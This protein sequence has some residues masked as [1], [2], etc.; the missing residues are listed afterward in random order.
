MNAAFHGRRTNALS[1]LIVAACVYQ[2]G[3][4]SCGCLDHHGWYQ[5]WRQ[6]VGE[7]P[8]GHGHTADTSVEASECEAA[9]SL[10]ALY[11]PTGVDRASA[12]V[13][14]YAVADI[15]AAREFLFARLATPTAD[16]GI[17][18]LAPPLRAEFQVYRL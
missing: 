9:P 12:P 6:V 16:K 10:D 8:C 7:P 11:R 5:A 15:E 14:V 4:P 3:A 17:A 1:L 2:L 13:G 18:L